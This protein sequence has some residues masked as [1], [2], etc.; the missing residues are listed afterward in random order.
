MLPLPP[1]HLGKTRRLQ[2]GA[3]LFQA[4]QDARG[5][6]VQPGNAAQALPRPDP[7]RN[8]S[9]R[10]G[11]RCTESDR[12]PA[13][14]CAQ[15]GG[16][17]PEHSRRGLRAMHVAV[18]H[19][20]SQRPATQGDQDR[21]STRLNSSHVKISYAVFCLKKKKRRKSK[22]TTE[23]STESRRTKTPK[24]SDHISQTL[25]ACS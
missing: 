24:A 9:A 18:D 11:D 17:H 3:R 6:P 15:A 23:K 8:R 4:V 12:C 13:K 19:C 25:S 2:E 7:V 16:V 10:H 20:L 14:R 22:S 5:Q 21:K 1:Y